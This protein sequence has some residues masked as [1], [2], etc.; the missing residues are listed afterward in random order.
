M[1]YMD[2]DKTYRGK[3][4]QELHKNSTSYIEQI[5][6]VTPPWNN[7]YTATYLPSLKPSPALG[8]VEYPFIAIA[9]RSTLARSGSTW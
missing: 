9:P 5:L 6:E 8:N 3:A 7:S 1:H 2:A 4:K